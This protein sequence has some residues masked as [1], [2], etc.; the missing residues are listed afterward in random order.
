MVVS[1]EAQRIREQV[2]ACLQDELT[3]DVSCDH[4]QDG[5]G[6]NR[7][8]VRVAIGIRSLN[9]TIAASHDS[10]HVA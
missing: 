2:I 10:F 3:V 7:V 6:E 9:V 4:E 5:M 1:D 8:K